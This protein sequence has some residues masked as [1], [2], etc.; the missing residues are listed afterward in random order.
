[1]IGGST[2]SDGAGINPLQIVLQDRKGPG[3]VVEFPGGELVV[4]DDQKPVLAQAARL[5]GSSG[6]GRQG[7][8][9]SV[10]RAAP[11]RAIRH[12]LEMLATHMQYGVDEQVD[13][14]TPQPLEADPFGVA[15]E[16]GCFVVNRI[17]P[18]LQG[19]DSKDDPDF[20]ALRAEGRAGRGMRHATKLIASD[21]SPHFSIGALSL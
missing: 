13:S 14:L 2:R 9:E 12:R 8:R 4:L 21:P 7:P 17:G 6:A 5:L 20:L 18:L 16:P 10:D 11:L 19:A 1:M 15:E 3:R